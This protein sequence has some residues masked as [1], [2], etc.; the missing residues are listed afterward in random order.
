[1]KLRKS[2]PIL[3][4]LD[5]YL[6]DCAIFSVNEGNSIANRVKVDVD[7]IVVTLSFAGFNCLLV[8]GEPSLF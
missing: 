8:K 3:N 1:M 2:M 6:C 4:I 7:L 5:Y